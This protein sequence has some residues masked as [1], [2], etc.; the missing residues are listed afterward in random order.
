MLTRKVAGSAPICHF[1]PRVADPRSYKESAWFFEPLS[2][3]TPHEDGRGRPFVPLVPYHLSLV[4]VIYTLRG[5]RQCRACPCLI[6]KASPPSDVAHHRAE[7]ALHSLQLHA[8][9]NSPSQRCPL[10][11]SIQTRRLQRSSLNF[12]PKATSNAM[13]AAFARRLGGIDQARSQTVYFTGGGQ[14]NFFT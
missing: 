5:A 7:R 10:A 2:V 11:R 8:P 4:L 3:H 9:P 6:P 1:V 13:E 14:S 12:P